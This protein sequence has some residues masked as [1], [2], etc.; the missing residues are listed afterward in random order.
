[1]QLDIDAE[2]AN[3]QAMSTGELAK[4]YAEVFGEQARSRHKTYLIRR[5]A[6]RM[7]ALAE[8]NLSK[9]G[10]TDG[11]RNWPTTPT[12]ASR[13]RSPILSRPGTSTAFPAC[14]RRRGEPSL[15][16]SCRCRAGQ[17]SANARVGR[18][19]SWCGRTVL[20]TTG[21]GTSRCLAWPK[22][23]PARTAT[24]SAVLRTGGQLMSRK[25]NSKTSTPTVRGVRDLHAE[26]HRRGGGKSYFSRW[27]YPHRDVQSQTAKPLRAGF[28]L[29]TLQ[30]ANDFVDGIHVGGGFSFFQATERFGPDPR[31]A[32]QISLRQTGRLPPADNLAR[33]QSAKAGIAFSEP[34]CPRTSP[35]RGKPD[36]AEIQVPRRRSSNSRSRAA[37]S[38]LRPPSSS[39]GDNPRHALPAVIRALRTLLPAASRAD[40]LPAASRRRFSAGIASST[41]VCS[42]SSTS[43]RYSESLCCI[44]KSSPKLRNC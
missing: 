37:C 38:S 11:P 23:S 19:A 35:R 12:F 17:S 39:S 9:S 24:D 2:V 5:I 42:S 27:Y 7:Q 36:S 16:S 28:R 30:H 3:L 40:A 18:F 4:R 29:H 34:R 33:R 15:T 21:S 10:A 31:T 1:M 32:C 44:A 26:L 25:N 14:E 8:G 43:P 41:A 13:R 22:R 20:N 6:W